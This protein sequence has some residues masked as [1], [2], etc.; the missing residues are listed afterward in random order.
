MYREWKNIEFSI[1][2]LYMNLETMRLRGRPRN[3]WQDKVKEYR[4]LVGGKG[5]KEKV[6]NRRAMEEAPEN[7]K[8]S[9]HSPH[10]NGMNE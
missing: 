6:R 8:E 7:S 4:R 1:K 10:V 2:V 3:S 5:C 9:L